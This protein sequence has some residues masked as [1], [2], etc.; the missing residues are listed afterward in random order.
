MRG[1]VKEYALPVR[2]EGLG[3]AL[4]QNLGQ[5]ETGNV[6]LRFGLLK[7]GDCDVTLVRDQLSSDGL[8]APLQMISRIAQGCVSVGQRVR[9]VRRKPS[10]VSQNLENTVFG[11]TL[12]VWTDIGCTSRRLRRSILPVGYQAFGFLNRLQHHLR[13]GSHSFITLPQERNEP[14]TGRLEGRYI[15]GGR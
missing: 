3:A 10:G 13:V 14:S 5:C 4:R 15:L 12:G 8:V 6:E 1:Q 11:Q 7:A 2:P 9:A